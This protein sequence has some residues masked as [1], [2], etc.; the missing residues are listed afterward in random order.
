M[1]YPDFSDCD[2]PLKEATL[3]LVRGSQY[4]TV[5]LRK[6]ALWSVIEA[7]NEYGDVVDLLPKEEMALYFRAE[8]GEDETGI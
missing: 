5:Y 1:T 3:T 6:D 2:P 7:V 8:R 4:I